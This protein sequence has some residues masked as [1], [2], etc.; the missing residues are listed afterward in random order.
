MNVLTTFIF[1]LVSHRGCRAVYSTNASDVERA[2]EDN[3][4]VWTEDEGL[5]GPLLEEWTVGKRRDGRVMMLPVT[6]NFYV[7]EEKA[8]RN[9]DVK[10]GKISPGKIVATSGNSKPPGRQISE[11]DLYL[12]GA[13]EKLVYRVDFMEKRLRRVE[14]MLYYAVAGNRVDH[15]PCADN[16]TRVGSKC[17]HFTGSAG[18]EYDWKVASKQ[19]KKLGG[20]LAEMESIE[21]NQDVITHIQTNQHL[22]G[23]LFFVITHCKDFWT[24]GLNPGLLW[25]WSNSARPV[26]APGSQNNKENPSAAIQGEGRCLKLAYNPALRSYSYRGGD[27]SVRYGYICELAENASSNEIRRLGRSRRIFDDEL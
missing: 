3:P 24:G 10:E 27:C 22:K 8:D 16:F 20:F 19:C 1:L 6:H 11:T 9:V 13:I 14:E 12:L 18:R 15:E 17:Y 4:S 5:W 26:K 7:A 25:I 23:N 21:E 2:S